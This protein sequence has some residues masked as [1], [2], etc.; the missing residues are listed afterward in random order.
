ME[1]K[2]NISE[3]KISDTKGPGTGTIN[4]SHDPGE[5]I[6]ADHSSPQKGDSPEDRGAPA[7]NGPDK[8]RPA[9][10][11][12]KRV[13]AVIGIIV[14]LSIYITAFISSL[15]ESP[16]TR[17]VLMAAIFSNIAFPVLIYVFGRLVFVFSGKHT[18]PKEE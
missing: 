8:N 7:M 5:K 10:P 16:M 1:N 12:W 14:I 13:T 4:I 9:S 11:P 3:N 6:T 2:K 18:D 17:S 15:C